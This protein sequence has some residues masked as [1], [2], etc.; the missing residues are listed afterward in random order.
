M[1]DIDKLI[2]QFERET[3]KKAILQHPVA[4]W[5]EGLEHQ[6]EL[7]GEMFDLYAD[8]FV[9]WLASRLAKAEEL[10]RSTDI[11]LDKLEH[12]DCDQLRE[13]G[14]CPLATL[15]QQIEDAPTM[16]LVWDDE[17]P[18]VFNQRDESRAEAFAD[19]C[20]TKAI[21]VKLLEDKDKVGE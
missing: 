15:E 16:L 14:R 9:E 20:G 1:I 18:T 7:T 10:K 2:E 11:L 5:T 21:N 8:E 13:H 6:G 3:G 19:L 4:L 17:E 12:N